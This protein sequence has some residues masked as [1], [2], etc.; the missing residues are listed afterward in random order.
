MAQHGVG[1]IVLACKG[2]GGQTAPVK[3]FNAQAFLPGLTPFGG[4]TIL[5]I[6]PSRLALA[7]HRAA[8]QGDA[9]SPLTLDYTNEQSGKQ[10]SYPAVIQTRDGLVH[11]VYTWHRLRIKHVC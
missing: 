1:Q 8:L 7:C 11:I 2:G 5:W 3:R 4:A 6:A 10:F 9:I